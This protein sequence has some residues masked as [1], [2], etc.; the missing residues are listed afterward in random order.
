MAQTPL[1]T[2]QCTAYNQEKYIRQTLEGFLAQKTDF[3]FEVIVHDD[4]STDGTADIIREYEQKYPHLFKCIY[5]PENTYSKGIKARPQYIMPLTRGKYVAV[6]E[7]D[8]YWADPYK[9][10]R[11]ADAMQAHPEC[12][13]S[14]H[15]VREVRED[16][17]ET[18]TLFPAQTVTP[19]VLSSRTFLEIGK[20]YS[21]H[22]SSY[23]FVSEK[24]RQYY[25]EAPDFTRDCDVGDE[26]Y[27]LYFGQL[28]SVYY[29][30]EIMSCYRRG[31]AGSWTTAHRKK[32]SAKKATHNRKMV[33]TLQR[34]DAYTQGKYHDICVD[35]ISR[36]MAVL[37]ITE[38]TCKD[39]FKSE[40][41]E[42]Y[43][44]MSASRRGFVA[45]AAVFPRLMRKVYFGRVAGQD[46]RH[47]I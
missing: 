9:L 37:N 40:N 46:K 23:F 39:F 42:Y 38:G 41:R 26:L 36:Q 16:G 5:Q 18:S 45:L 15:R 47:G 3:P 8:D 12:Y 13:M 20:V 1:V 2:V 7:G 29:L 33:I 14:V 27:M 11:Q 34:F 28:G 4:A 24:L 44:A 25:A 10:Q 19:G 21:F 31:V 30:D 22:T 6:C 32:L 17:E 43:R 35:R